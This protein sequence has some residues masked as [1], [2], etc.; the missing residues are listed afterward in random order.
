MIIDSHAHILHRKFTEAGVTPDM[1][2]REAQDAGVGQVIGIATVRAE[3]DTYLDLAAADRR[4]R[5]AAGI[6][7][8]DVHEEAETSVDELIRLGSN[9]LVV[10][11]GE[12]GLDY[13]HEGTTHKAAQMRAFYAHIEAAKTCKLPLVI[14]T[15][16]AEEDTIAVLKEHPGV[17]FVLH[18]FTGSP[19]LAEQ[20]LALGGYISFSGVVSFKSSHELRNIAVSVPADRLLVETDAPYLA[21]EPLRGR[22]CTPAMTAHTLAALA[23]TRGVEATELARQTTANTYRLFNRL[24]Q[25]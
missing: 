19:W 13:Y 25:L 18:C 9:P 21:P 8:G 16:S 5:V 23:R 20:G 2:L 12:T 6:H 17:P 4:V 15:R 1:L 11:L 3:W 22:L 7:P 24:P 14:H 10:G